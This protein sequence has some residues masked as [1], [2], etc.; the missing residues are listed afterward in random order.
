MTPQIIRTRDE[1]ASLDDDT[2]VVTD[3]ALA[4]GWL[5]HYRK[6]A[7]RAADAHRLDL[8]RSGPVVVIATGD[9]VRAAREALKEATE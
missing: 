7:Y 9:H 5:T 1:L 3:T 2:L 8:T 6:S 4:H